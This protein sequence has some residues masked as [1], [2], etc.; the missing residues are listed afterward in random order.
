[1]PNFIT[2]TGAFA[3]AF[4][5]CIAFSEKRKGI[6]NRLL[7]LKR[8]AEHFDYFEIARVNATFSRNANIFFVKNPIFIV[9]YF[10]DNLKFESPLRATYVNHLDYDYNSDSL[11]SEGP[12]L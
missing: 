9:Q 8:T 4:Y 7:T 2:F 12:M 5:A 10:P 1:M 3:L 11:K 6:Q